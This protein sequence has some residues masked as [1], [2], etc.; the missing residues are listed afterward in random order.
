MKISSIIAVLFTFSCHNIIFG[1]AVSKYIVVDQFGYTTSAKKVAVIRDPQTGYDAAESFTPSNNYTLVDA[2]SLNTVFNGTLTAWN[3]GAIDSTSGDKAWWFDFSSVTTPGSYYVLDVDNNVRSFQF[4]ISDT[5]YKN[6]LK[7][8]MRMYFYQRAGF[9]KEAKYA[10]IGWADGA[11]HLGPLQDKNCRAYNAKTDIKTE[12]DLHGAWY[13]AGDLNR[14]TPWTADYVI[15]L[16]KTYNENPSVFSDDYNIPESGNEIPDIIDEIKWGMDWLLR[17]N[18]ANG[19]SLSALGCSHASPPSSATGQSIYG[20]ANTISTFRSASAFALGATTYRKLDPSKFGIYADTL[21]ARAIKA[22]KWGMANPSVKFNN[23]GS[24]G[25]GAGNQ[26]TDSLGRFTAKMGAALYLY[27]LTAD[28]SYLNVF[29]KYYK[30]FPLFQ[31]YYF[32]SQYFDEGQ[33]LQFY[34]LSLPKINTKVV[35]D[36][37]TYLKTAYNKPGDYVGKLKNQADPYRAY[38][39]EYN[40]GSNQYKS[41]YGL[42]FWRLQKY[43]IEKTNKDFYINSAEEYLHYIH[44]VNPLQLVY[45]TNMSSYGAE[46]S[47]NEMY[48]TWFCDGSA[49]WDRVGKSTYGPAPGYVPGGANV[50]YDWSSCCPSGCGSSSNN[51]LCFAESVSPPKGQ[52]R[53]KSYKDFNTN[54]PLN[55]WE[56]SEPSCGYQT[57]YI[58]LLSKFTK[59]TEVITSESTQ[60]LSVNSLFVFPNPVQKGGIVEVNFNKKHPSKIEL[61]D[62]EGR[63]L[64]TKS[65]EP[66]QT[67][68]K[69]SLENIKPGLYFLLTDT[70]S[71]V[72]KTKVIVQ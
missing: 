19:S 1:Q 35:T 2:N 15:T 3:N 38:I 52:P 56:I 18:Q 6:I 17:M 50:F 51:A 26:E 10:G 53:Q 36:I 59:L 66:N 21:Q 32:V 43:D 55:S 70:D 9:A 61:M 72:F 60:E 5:V 63:I 31:W 23:G 12:K 67:F 27:E 46:K 48:H 41:N 11:S 29:E 47:A 33:D 65:V 20:M 34:Y 39:L 24:T 4:A 16:L 68:A 37:R 71:G 62:L 54:W 44:G 8:A 7:A 45:L 14:Y 58:R 69:V 49:K 22:W 13:D 40:W 28:T 30:S 64:L 25:I 57:A 42:S